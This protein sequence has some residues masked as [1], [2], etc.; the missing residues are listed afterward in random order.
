MLARVR[1]VNEIENPLRC[2][3]N[4]EISF[5]MLIEVSANREKNLPT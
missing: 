5:R 1:K 3:E 4:E 2:V